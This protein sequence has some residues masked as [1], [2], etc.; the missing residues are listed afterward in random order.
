MA[1]PG[2]GLPR[3]IMPTAWAGLVVSCRA[4]AGVRPPWQERGWRLRLRLLPGLSRF[5][6]N[7]L[8]QGVM[9][10]ARRLERVQAEGR[11]DDWGGGCCSS[12]SPLHWH[13]RWFIALA[14]LTRCMY[15]TAVLL[16]SC[17]LGGYFVMQRVTAKPLKNLCWSRSRSMHANWDIRAAPTVQCECSPAVTQTSAPLH[18]TSLR[19]KSTAARTVAFHFMFHGMNEPRRSA[20]ALPRGLDARVP[21]GH[22]AMPTASGNA[23]S[24]SNATRPSD[25]D[26]QTASP[27]KALTYASTLSHLLESHICIQLPRVG[28]A[29]LPPLLP[30]ARAVPR[31]LLLQPLPLLPLPPPPGRSLVAQ[32][33]PSPPVARL[34]QRASRGPASAL[35]EKPT[36]SRRLLL[37]SAVLYVDV[38]RSQ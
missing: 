3:Y 26:S 1:W 29:P 7:R 11:P 2:T 15:H 20:Q 38:F 17:Y 21:L 9:G 6:E 32:D 12:S 33:A 35:H 19:C 27:I 28:C 18:C 25:P 34:R 31:C 5:P 24:Q 4:C 22:N 23:S 16:L 8:R 10:R 14:G 13:V 30:G 37:L 36:P